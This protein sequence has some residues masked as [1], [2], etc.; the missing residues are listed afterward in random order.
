LAV[1]VRSSEASIS[2]SSIPLGGPF[3]L[4]K[5]MLSYFGAA[6]AEWGLQR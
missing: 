5:V 2:L 4:P 1:L 3:F 6:Q